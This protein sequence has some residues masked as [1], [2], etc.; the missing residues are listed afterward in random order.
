MIGPERALESEF[1]PPHSGWCDYV[2]T[3][4]VWLL[5]ADIASSSFLH[6]LFDVAVVVT[7]KSITKRGVQYEWKLRVVDGTTAVRPV[8]SHADL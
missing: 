6:L 1:A 4:S 8:R 3:T 7:A 2:G 5:P